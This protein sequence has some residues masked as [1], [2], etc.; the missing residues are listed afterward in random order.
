VARPEGGRVAL[1][2]GGGVEGSS[3]EGSVLEGACSRGEALSSP[4]EMPSPLLLLLRS[5]AS[6]VPTINDNCCVD[7]DG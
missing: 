6:E 3:L 5:S 2:E 4:L 1:A 7:V